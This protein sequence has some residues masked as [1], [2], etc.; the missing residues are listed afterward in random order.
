MASQ[1]ATIPAAEVTTADP[2]VVGENDDDLPWYQK[3]RCF[4]LALAVLGI[5][6]AVAGYLLGQGGSEEPV[7]APLVQPTAAPVKTTT[8]PSSSPTAFHIFKPPAECFAIANG[9]ALNDQDFLNTT[10]VSISFDVSLTADQDTSSWLTPFEQGLQSNFVPA[11][12]GCP[13]ERRLMEENNRELQNEQNPSRY[14]IANADSSLAYLPNEPCVSGAEQPCK[15]VQAIMDLYVK[16]EYVSFFDVVNIYYDAAGSDK[17]ATVGVFGLSTAQFKGISIAEIDNLSPTEAPSPNPIGMPITTPTSAPVSRRVFLQSLLSQHAP[18]QTSAFNWLADTDT[19]EPD[20][21]SFNAEAQW[22]ERYAMAAFYYSTGG[23]GWTDN[24]NWLSSTSICA[25]W[26][27]INECKDNQVFDLTMEANNMVGSLP[28]DI[29]LLTRLTKLAPFENEGISG[30]I[31]TEVGLLTAL[32]ALELDVTSLTGPIPTEIGLLKRLKQFYAHDSFISGSIPSEIGDT[33]LVTFDV[34]NTLLRGNIPEQLWSLT[35]LQSLKIFDTEL[36][37]SISTRIGQL[38]FLE[39]LEIDDCFFTGT[40][41]SE[42]GELKFLK[43][44]TGFSNQ[45]TGSIPSSIGLLTFLTTLELDTNL[46]TGTI[47]AEIVSC[48]LNVL[49]LY[50]NSLVGDVP[51]LPTLSG[52]CN[53]NSNCFSGFSNAIARNCEVDN[54]DC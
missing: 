3:Y 2:D 14:A 38:R 31:P 40:I 32:T 39:M 1:A 23:D 21:N 41:P 30:S 27:G 29:G 53:L 33:N 37:G 7:P 18:L 15:R 6:G 34:Y 11:L 45:L 42:I 46:L 50:N 10:S 4:I 52:D 19:W 12:A 43:F 8:A 49:H 13:T 35:Y 17:A 51:P 44:M 16:D 48:P 24:R 28:T 36:D 5:G 54:S 22:L 26:F 47:P 20:A 9:V 25:G